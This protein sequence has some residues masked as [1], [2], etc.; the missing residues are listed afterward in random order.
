MAALSRKGVRG[1]K[2]KETGKMIW[3]ETEHRIVQKQS[4]NEAAVPDSVD[5]V[6]A[7]SA[8]IIM[9]PQARKSSRLLSGN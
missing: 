8:N 5:K 7:K 1:Q 9:I 2:N 3:R 4:N 6:R